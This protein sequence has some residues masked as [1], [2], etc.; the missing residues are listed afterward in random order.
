MDEEIISNNGEIK[1]EELQNSENENS[2]ISKE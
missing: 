1:N 2:S